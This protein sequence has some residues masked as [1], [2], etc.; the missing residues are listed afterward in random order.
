[1]IVCWFEWLNR[2][3]TKEIAKI[4]WFFAEK[5]IKFDESE[6]EKANENEILKNFVK[7]DWKFEFA[8]NFS[9]EF[10]WTIENDILWNDRV[11]LYLT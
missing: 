6:S 10:S 4:D 2:F 11:S 8:L 3:F 9:S 5:I 7:F 1:M